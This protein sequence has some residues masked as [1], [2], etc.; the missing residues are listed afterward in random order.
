MQTALI[1][2]AIAAGGET[3]SAPS[4]VPDQFRDWFDAASRDRLRVPSP[5]ARRASGFRYV[6]IGG[7]GGERMP[8]YFAQNARALRAL[9]VPRDAIHVLRP[10]SD[11]TVEENRSRV[12]D[13]LVAIAATGPERLVIVAHSRG[14]CDALD[15]AL[16][17]PRFITDRVEALFLVQG[18]FGGSPLADRVLG[19]GQAMDGRMPTGSRVVAYLVG[20]REARLVHRGDHWGLTGLARET[21]RAFWQRELREHPEA[22][23]VIG[24]KVFYIESRAEPSRLRL[25][26]RAAAHYLATYYGPGDGMVG[27]GDQTVPGLGTSLGVLEAGHADL[28][29]RFPASRAGRRTRSALM[30]SIAVAVGQQ[31]D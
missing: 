20:R 26:Q 31:A 6:F 10:S 15:F 25:V 17:Q 22:A 23:S 27:E 28:T 24:P 14:A 12:R 3:G 4:I 30:Q 7:L 11:R 19:A 18:P 29:R 1:L 16:H 8:G 13:D 21:S 9:G 5:V 2:L